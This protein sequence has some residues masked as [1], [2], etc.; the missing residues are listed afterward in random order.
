MGYS[1]HDIWSA[2]FIFAKVRQ[3]NGDLIKRCVYKPP[4]SYAIP[5]LDNKKIKCNSKKKRKIERDDV[6]EGERVRKIERGKYKERE[7]VIR[8]EKKGG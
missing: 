2:L 8:I 7:R 6:R 5:T 3:K 1:H 4:L